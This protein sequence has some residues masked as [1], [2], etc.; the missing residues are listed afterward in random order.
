MSE[1]TYTIVLADNTVLKGLKN[2]DY[3]GYDS[4]GYETTE[5]SGLFYLKDIYM[6]EDLTEIIEE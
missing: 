6:A 5:G 3:A 1:Q 4:Y 2:L